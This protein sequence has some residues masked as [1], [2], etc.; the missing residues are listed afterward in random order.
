MYFQGNHDKYQPI[1]AFFEK[2]KNGSDENR[3]I[4][5]KKRNVCVSILRKSRK[6][7]F[8]KLNEKQITDKSHFQKTVKLFFKEGSSPDKSMSL[9]RRQF[10]NIKY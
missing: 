4:F 6:D 9:K 3:S 7:Y 8:A 10:F 5:C 2:R 1:K